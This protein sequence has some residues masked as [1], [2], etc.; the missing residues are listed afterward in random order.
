VTTRNDGAA[1]RQL[2]ALF[3]I[4][5][6][7]EL[8]D[9]QLL[10]QFSSARGEV[11]EVAFEAL[12]ERHGAMVLRVCRAQLVDPHDTQD[13]F[14]ATFLILVKRARSLWVR[15][16]LGP[17]LHQVAF[18]TAACS[19]SAVAR[20]RKHE[21]R[22]AEMA[23]SLAGQED[24]SNSELE[25]VLHEEINRLP[26]CYRVPIVL[27]DL[28]GQTCEEA[29]RR[30]G[31][32]IGTVKS[33]RFRGRARLRDRLIRL[34]L[35]PSVALGAALPLD[36]AL[37]TL[38]QGAVRT[39]VRA[40]SDWMTAGEVSA[41]VRTL[42][43]GVLK[44]MFL[45]KLRTTASAVF[46]VAL[47]SAALGAVALVAAD[48]SN[49]TADGANSVA[50][51]PG[52][53]NEYR[54]TSHA[55]TEPGKF[56]VLSLP[57]AIRIGLE[58]ADEVHV[59]SVGGNG[60]PS[61]IAPRD[62]GVDLE[63][64]KA[65]VM[66][67]VRSIEQQYRNLALAR[68]QLAVANTTATSVERFVA[69]LT[70]ELKLGRATIADLAE[71]SQR[72]EQFK[73]DVVTRS[74]DLD[75]TERQLRNLLGLSPAD[76]RQIVAVTPPTKDRLEPDWEECLAVMLVKQPELVRI[77]AL[78]NE[79]ES[80]VSADGL[81]RLERRKA[82]EKQVINQATHSLARLLKEI[83]A[84]YEKFKTAARLRHAAALR[85]ESQKAFY[86][87]GRIT[88][89]RYL[90]A[91][92]QHATSLAMEDQ[93]KTDYNHSIVALE[94]AK[95][96]LLE[97]DQITVVDGPKSAVSIASVP[98]FAVKGAWYEPPDA[99]KRTT[100]E[101]IPSP[102]PAALAPASRTNVSESQAKAASPKADLGGKTYSF[103]VTIGAGSKPFEIR[104]SLTVT[105]AQSESPPSVR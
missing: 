99:K 68:V 97:H 62:R 73:L 16:S 47:L 74:S 29:A 7:R 49:E 46:A 67:H 31:R 52:N 19:R 55:L 56:W 18:R 45:S 22:A 39:A 102:A 38:P 79:A 94:E 25:R 27:C 78:V 88:V 3:N 65:E 60:T 57:E 93:Y 10:E 17:W 9:G 34:R 33:W 83:D 26:E 92:T 21:R 77:K 104:G 75:T 70:A 89:D 96:T 76:G 101:V 13:A 15:D 14:Q 12:V 91:V 85:L 8:S 37:T 5:A 66:A 98:D 32:P 84:N 23:A 90:D 28:Q 51:R 35:A 20:R 80:D 4:G 11:A 63:R 42:V 24:R 95:G 43:E 48:D 64:F 86:E 53:E 82:Y 54:P 36:A 81:M 58:N 105:P 50:R 6:I 1:L 2:E 103:Q 44:T 71:A 100:R 87:E 41:S 59:I 61:K 30:M 40:L 69:H 72:L